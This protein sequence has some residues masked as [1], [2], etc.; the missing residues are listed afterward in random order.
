M[1]ALYY[2][3]SPP[4]SATKSSIRHLSPRWEGQR[5]HRELKGGGGS[6]RH[7]IRSHRSCFSVTLFPLPAPREEKFLFQGKWSPFPFMVKSRLRN[8]V[9]SSI[10]FLRSTF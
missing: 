5:A 6:V 3:L 9:Q 10:F 2:S 1:Q 7:Q 4:P 8:L